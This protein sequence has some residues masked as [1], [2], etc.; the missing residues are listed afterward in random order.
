MLGATRS[1][2]TTN[3]GATNGPRLKSPSGM[4]IN[5]VNQ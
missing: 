5:R 1:P 2:S 3:D 4:F